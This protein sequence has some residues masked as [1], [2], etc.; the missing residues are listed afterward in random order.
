ML[1]TVNYTK[2]EG[3]YAEHTK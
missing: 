2:S 1:M 3:E